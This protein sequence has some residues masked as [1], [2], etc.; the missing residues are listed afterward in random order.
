M[1]VI[2]GPASCDKQDVGLV[3]LVAKLELKALFT[4]VVASRHYKTSINILWKGVEG[5]KKLVD[6]FMIQNDDQ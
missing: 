3:G 5:S 4:L 2:V 1:L 6:N